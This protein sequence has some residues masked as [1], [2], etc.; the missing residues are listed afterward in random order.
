MNPSSPLPAPAGLDGPLSEAHVGTPRF[1]TP[2][3]VSEDRRIME[4]TGGRAPRRCRDRPGERQERVMRRG[5]LVDAGPTP[6][7]LGSPRH[8]YIRMLLSAVARPAR[9]ASRSSQRGARNRA[10]RRGAARAR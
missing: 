10:G 5:Q 2:A 9:S 6:D 8:E 3:T 7:V 1:F 4:A